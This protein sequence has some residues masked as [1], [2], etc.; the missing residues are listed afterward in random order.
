MESYSKLHTPIFF[1]YVSYMDTYIHDMDHFRI[2]LHMFSIAVHYS[3]VS[4][5]HIVSDIFCLTTQV[6]FPPFS[7]LR[8]GRQISSGFPCPLVL[9]RLQIG[10]SAGRLAGD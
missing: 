2:S 6:L 3:V 9:I 5:A 1:T 10:R 7:T 4:M 8:S